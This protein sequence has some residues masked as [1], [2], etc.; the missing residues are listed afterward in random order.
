M[1]LKS[2]CRGRFRVWRNSWQTSDVE[3][4]EDARDE[5]EEREERETGIGAHSRR[6]LLVQEVAVLDDACKVDLQPRVVNHGVGLFVAAHVKVTL[7]DEIDTA[8]L[9]LTESRARE[10]SVDRPRVHDGPT[11]SVKVLLVPTVRVCVRVRVGVSVRVTRW[12]HR[13]GKGA[14]YPTVVRITQQLAR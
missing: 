2:L 6:A 14:P 8:V 9:E 12:S 5:K 4:A 1:C 11:D 3:R 13:L 7:L 10:V